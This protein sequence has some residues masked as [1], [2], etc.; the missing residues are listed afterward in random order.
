MKKKK[1]KAITGVMKSAEV[2]LWGNTS[3]LETDQKSKKV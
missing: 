3:I 1:M 2:E